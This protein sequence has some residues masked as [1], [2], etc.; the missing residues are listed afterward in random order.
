MERA[1]VEGVVK[2]AAPHLKH[3]EYITTNSCRPEPY[4]TRYAGTPF[5]VCPVSVW[6]R[7]Q[8]MKHL[9][10]TFIVNHWVARLK[11]G[12]GPSLRWKLID[13]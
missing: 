9:R 11:R 13:H 4:N 6:F 3:S 7:T 5:D 1:R 8:F 2:N 12:Y 10:V